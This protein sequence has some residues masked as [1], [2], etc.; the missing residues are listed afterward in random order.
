MRHRTELSLA[1]RP[2]GQA[3]RSPARSFV[4]PHPLDFDWRFTRLT[5]GL[6]WET[7]AELANPESGIALLGTP[8]LVSAKRLTNLDAVTLFDR[9]PNHYGSASDGMTFTCCDVLRDPI[10]AGTNSVV[11][12][13]P[14]WYEAE[15][16]GFLWT[17]STLAGAGAHV[18][19]SLPPAET[20]PGIPDERERITAAAE[21]FGLG[22]VR[23]IEGA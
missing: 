16:I 4:V 8:S 21:G 13:D 23:M 9:N 1:R 18:L 11:V 12:A 15:T 14:P 6:I 10:A 7:I 17:A 19:L 22:L 20:R 3:Q 5:V 2:A